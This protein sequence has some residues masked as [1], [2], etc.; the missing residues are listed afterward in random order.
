MSRNGKAIVTGVCNDFVTNHD[1]AKLRGNL[2]YE[3]G[4]GQRA[5]INFL[6]GVPGV[7]RHIVNLQLAN[8]KALGDYARIIGEV[9][10]AIRHLLLRWNRPLVSL[11]RVGHDVQLL[12]KSAFELPSKAA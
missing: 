3:R 6:S 4:H 11:R 9:S 12:F 1:A 2:T 8:L 7:N 5:I 10:A